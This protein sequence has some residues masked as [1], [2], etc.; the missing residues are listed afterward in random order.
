MFP[1]TK[2]FVLKKVKAALNRALPKARRDLSAAR[3]EARKHP[4]EWTQKRVKQAER[5]L[6]GFGAL[7]GIPWMP[8][9]GRFRGPMTSTEGRFSGGPK[10]TESVSFDFETG[11]ARSYEWYQLGGVIRGKY[12]LNTF[13]Y[14]SA[15][16]YHVRELRET[17]KIL[18]IKY[19]ELE[20][21]RGLNNLDG[22]VQYHIS[23]LAKE[24]VR[25]KYATKYKSKFS[26]N[27]SRK[28][29]RVLES[30]G[31]QVSER[32]IDKA[33]AK[34]ELDRETKNASVRE[35]SKEYREKRKLE[36][37]E[38]LAKAKAHISELQKTKYC[39]SRS[40]KFGS[41]R[42]SFDL[43]NTSTILVDTSF[44]MNLKPVPGESQK[45]CI[46]YLRVMERLN[47]NK[48]A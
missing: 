10:D 20:A 34:A 14:S 39:Y 22:V 15:T 6:K 46:A 4:G 29:L 27:N 32:E 3:K 2:E 44:L 25:A 16:S 42:V 19:I 21:P 45:A 7:P 36:R 33:I 18:G 12:V 30:L 28:Q 1:M 43:Y 38:Y 23:E 47:Q 8:R 24:T 48:G 41:G 13:R 9:L 11:E 35:A 17:L 26:V 31:F 40:R 37:L 5:V